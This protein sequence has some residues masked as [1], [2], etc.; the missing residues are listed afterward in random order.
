MTTTERLRHLLKDGCQSSSC[1]YVKRPAMLTTGPCRCLETFR[2]H[3]PALL[4]VVDAAR[5]QYNH[6]G[7]AHDSRELAG[8]TLKLYEALAKLEKETP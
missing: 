7:M 4:A 1:R 8:A 6:D 5:E 3:M 2:D